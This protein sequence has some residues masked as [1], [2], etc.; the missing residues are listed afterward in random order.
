M[1]SFLD[2]FAKLAVIYITE[3]IISLEV[4]ASNFVFLQKRIKFFVHFHFRRF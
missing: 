4:E 1:S 2:Q 3:D